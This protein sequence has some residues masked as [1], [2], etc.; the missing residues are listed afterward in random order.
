MNAC[1][2]PNLEDSSMVPS[3]A[4]ILPYLT[5][6]GLSQKEAPRSPMELGG[7]WRIGH[8]KESVMKSLYVIML[9]A[10]VVMFSTTRTFAQS[11]AGSS[12]SPRPAASS[13]TKAP[14]TTGMAPNRSGSGTSTSGGS[15]ANGDQGRD[16][17]PESSK[18]VKPLDEQHKPER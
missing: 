14:D 2:K 15:D 7:L 11:S 10:S 13:A 17:M 3:E 1:F 12:D 8:A 18:S 9:T 16:A 5:A 6:D 4:A